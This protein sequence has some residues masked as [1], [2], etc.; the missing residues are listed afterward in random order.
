MK[1]VS[2][3]QLAKVK[4]DPF[5][6]IVADDLILFRDSLAFRLIR[7][8]CQ[9]VAR[10]KMTKNFIITEKES[11]R[12]ERKFH[13]GAGSALNCEDRRERKNCTT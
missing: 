8:I 1:K 6:V 10:K 13:D 3:F 12:N 4:I 7:V 2:S 11:R 9:A 5:R